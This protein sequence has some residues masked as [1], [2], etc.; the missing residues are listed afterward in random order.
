ML[1][2]PVRHRPALL[3]EDMG[4]A[5]HVLLGDMLA[6]DQLLAD[7]V[8][9]MVA[10][11]AA[12][13]LAKG[14]FLGRETKVHFA[15]PLSVELVRKKIRLT[16]SLRSTPLPHCL[17]EEG[18]AW[19]SSLLSPGQGGE[20]ARR[21]GEGVLHIPQLISNSPAAP[22]AAADT[23]GHDGVF[24]AAPLAFDQC[25]AGEGARRSCP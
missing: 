9:Q 1:L 19:R 4:P 17:G 13:L 24:H 3:V 6:V 8:R 23:H 21:A 2:G 14:D 25:V 15:L 7:V 18:G 10:K 12:N 5:D 22:H 11:E 20:V 16:A